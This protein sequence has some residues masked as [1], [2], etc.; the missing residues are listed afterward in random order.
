M[1][2]YEKCSKFEAI[3]ND[4]VSKNWHG[5]VAAENYDIWTRKVEMVEKKEILLIMLLV[6]D[7]FTTIST[8][9]SL[10]RSYSL[11]NK[12]KKEP[13]CRYQRV[14]PRKNPKEFKKNRRNRNDVI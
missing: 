12:K 6:H 7:S 9:M 5:V 13:S 4:F 3:C 11:Q 2:I 1:F 8:Y 10:M 14:L